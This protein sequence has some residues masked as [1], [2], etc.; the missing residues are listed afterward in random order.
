MKILKR[1]DTKFGKFLDPLLVLAIIALFVIPAITL[2]NLTPGYRPPPEE[3]NVLGVTEGTTMSI[4]PHTE[5][6]DGISLSKFTQTSASSHTL[7][8]SQIPHKE[9]I[10]TN[11][12][13]S[14]I[15][16]TEKEKMIHV[17]SAIERVAP[18]T[19]LSLV[20]RKTKFVILDEAGI[21]YPPTL[22]VAPGQIMDVS[23][24]IK[25]P[26]DVNFTTGF[27]LDL[28]IE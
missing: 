9:G 22:Y 11:K 5:P 1:L 19:K 24:E 27:S 28:T 25:S 17:T 18:G 13:F 2:T 20:V 12:L 15:N 21:T 16:G 3:P 10:H 7:Y 26:V 4:R 14:A 8:L 6:Y 23:L